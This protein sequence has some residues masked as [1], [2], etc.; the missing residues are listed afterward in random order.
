MPLNLS[1]SVLQRRVF[2]QSVYNAHRAY[3]MLGQTEPFLS[4][5][6]L[7]IDVGA[8]VGMYTHFWAGLAKHVHSFEAVE[9]VFDQ[10]KLVAGRNANVTAYNMAVGSE[11]KD[12]VTFY[13]GDKRLSNSGLR[14]LV[15]GQSTTIKMVSLDGCRFTDVGFIKIDVEGNELDVLQ[16][17][18][19][20]I[21]RDRPTIMCE[22]YPK[23]ND[24][25]V[26]LTFDWLMGR[27][28][29]CFYNIKGQGLYEITSVEDGVRVASD[30]QLIAQHDGDFLF[31][32]SENELPEGVVI[33][34]D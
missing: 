31:Y 23:F 20:L 13:V 25:P 28:Y 19:F 27:G 8:A 4:K 30:D 12:E 22:V 14:D 3:F 11:D 6:K 24:G 15:G 5:D 2:N 1:D 32:P 33:H 17:A 34:G 18:R 16:G 10:L 21:E 26:E 7:A 9:P 29:R